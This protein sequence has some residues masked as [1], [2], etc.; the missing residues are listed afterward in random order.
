MCA[1]F[2]NFSESGN[3]PILM[4]WLKC[5][6]KIVLNTVEHF[7]I[8]D[9]GILLDFLFWS[10]LMIFEI[11]FSVQSGKNILF[12]IVGGIKSLK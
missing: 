1:I 4:R 11:S 5:F 10:S 7:L 2:P 3:S 6:A 9:I 12:M 8:T